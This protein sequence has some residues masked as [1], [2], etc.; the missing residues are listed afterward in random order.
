MLRT[1]LHAQLLGRLRVGLSLKER[2]CFL[3]KSME[4]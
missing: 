4:E 2:D 1:V 3:D